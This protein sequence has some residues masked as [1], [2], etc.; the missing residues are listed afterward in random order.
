MVNARK[1]RVF[2]G[3]QGP[4]GDDG[5]PGRA[6]A[7]DQRLRRAPLHDHRADEHQIRPVEIPVPQLAGIQVHQ[8][9]FPR[10]RKHRRHRQQSQRG[11][12]RPLADEFQRVLETPERIRKF[13]IEQ[14]DSHAIRELI[15]FSPDWKGYPCFCRRSGRRL[16]TAQWSD[17]G[18]HWGSNAT[19]LPPPA[20]AIVFRFL[21]AKRPL[22]PIGRRE[23]SASFPAREPPWAVS[24]AR[25]RPGHRETP[26]GRPAQPRCRIG[27]EP[28]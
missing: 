14:Q 10:R 19:E 1:L 26:R 16:N 28:T 2:A 13:R 3:E 6:T 9:L 11:Q 4:A 7:R 27:G 17:P 12:R 21:V 15:P 22:P 20:M 23:A 5:L 18:R 8:A 25:L 24:R